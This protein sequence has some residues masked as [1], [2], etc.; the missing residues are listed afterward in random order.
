M[1]LLSSLF[2]SSPPVTLAHPVFGALTLDRGAGVPCW[3]HEVYEGE[4][5]LAISIDTR[6]SEEPTQGQVEFFE[7]ITSDLDRAV[8]PLLPQL[9]VSHEEMHGKALPSDWRLAFKLAGMRVPL[10]GDANFDWDIAFECLTDNSRFL[11]T[12]YFEEGRLVHVSIDT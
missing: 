1:G 12:C 10:D 9:A 8:Q 3:V 5:G 11:Y 4:E 6:N 2:G 7:R